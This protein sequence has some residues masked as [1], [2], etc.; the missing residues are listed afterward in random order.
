M[1]G[2]LIKSISGDEKEIYDQAVS[3]PLQSF[4]WGEFK[5]AMG[6]SVERVCV[7]DNEKNA[8]AFQVSF[9]KIPYTRG[10][11]GYFPKGCMPDRIQIDAL[12]EIAAR[13]KAVFIKL[14]P[15]VYAGS[16]GVFEKERKFL[17]EN[18]ALEGKNLFTKYNFQ[19]DLTPGPDELFSNLRSK[20]RYNVRLAAKKG[21]EIIE[22]TTEGGM[23]IYIRLMQETTSRQKFFS[24]TPR[25]YR[26]MWKVIG[27]R[28]NSMMRIFHAMYNKQPLVTW[29]IF[30][31]NG[32]LY[33]PYGASSDAYRE[34]MASN[35]MMWEMIKYGHEK[36]CSCFDLWGSLGP[37]PDV[38]DP[39][40]GFHH[41][42]EG[43]NPV[44]VKNIGT[45]D[46]VYKKFFYNSF[47]AADKIRWFFLRRFRK[48]R[49]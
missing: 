4:A 18:G 45:Y 30:L 49:H 23:E 42:K 6:Q 47:N 9:H 21:V 40:Y 26:V 27:E 41:F 11:V 19:L 48:A 7:L 35:L 15:N 20:T 32:K 25:Y 38:N 2:L 46:L 5:K 24:H 17:L 43:Y 31:F 22:D 37:A 3:H 39:W 14:E 44:L 34:V 8:G 10:T 36:S 1:S 16:E 33:Y 12:K 13:Q 29:I 28:E